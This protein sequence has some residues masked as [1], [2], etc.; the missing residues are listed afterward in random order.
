MNGTGQNEPENQKQLVT[1]EMK[2]EKLNRKR[3]I[4]SLYIDFYVRKN[5]H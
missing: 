2:N 1:P 5:R 3:I 4:K